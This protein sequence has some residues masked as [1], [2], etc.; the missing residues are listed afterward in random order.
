[1]ILLQAWGGPGAECASLNAI[2]AHNLLGVVLLQGLAL[3]E[4]LCFCCS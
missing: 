3:L 4:C 2:V 1:M